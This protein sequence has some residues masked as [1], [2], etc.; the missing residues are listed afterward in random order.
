[1]G[2][3]KVLNRYI[4]PDFDPSIIP[5]SYSKRDRNGV[6][7]VRTMLPF[8][9]RCKTCGEYMYK[10]K[11]F[12]S[13]M[14][15]VEGEKS[16]YMGIRRFRFYIKCSVCSNEISF[17]TD[18]KNTDYELESGASRN[19]ENWR[20]TQKEIADEEEQR[21]KEE[22]MDAMKGLENRTMD[23]KMEMDVLD[24]LD[25]ITAINRRHERID[26]DKLLETVQSKK[27]GVFEKHDK[28]T[29]D[30]IIKSVTFKSQQNK[31]A[32]VGGNSAN[33]GKDG[34]GIEKLISQQI[35]A[36][37]MAQAKQQPK[38]LNV[39]GRKKRKTEDSSSSIDKDDADK[40]EKKSEETAPIDEANE[41]HCAVGEKTMISNA[42]ESNQ[43]VT[44]AI[45]SGLGGLGNYGSDSD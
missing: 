20:D 14:E 22:E 43:S 11:K 29:D 32:S 8:S 5:K 17:L 9:V 3:R 42:N 12:N 15:K 33:I 23:S 40:R 31:E 38:L 35:Q 36:A 34:E 16:H 41:K 13:R 6:I 44:S 7:E 25:E 45:S 24:A 2:E 10:G 39:V 28:L 1:M 18:P 19:F 30:E 27:E 37:K 26:T 4:P 21:T